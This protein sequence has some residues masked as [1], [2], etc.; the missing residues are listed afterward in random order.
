MKRYAIT[1]LGECLIDFN[2]TNQESGHLLLEGN[3][4]GA[5]A[6]VLAAA[7]KLGAK[8]C[9]IG[10]VGQDAFGD[11]LKYSLQS[12]NIDTA[13]LVSSEIFPTT[14]AFVSVNENGDRNFSFYRKST[15]DLMLSEDEI[16]YKSISESEIFHF[17]SV[18]MTSEPSRT[19]TLSAVR[20]AK[21]SNC[22]ISYDPNLRV[23]LWDN[24]DEAKHVI[25]DAMKLADIVKVSEEEALFLT[26]KHSPAEAMRQ[27]FEENPMRLLFVTLGPRGCL[28]CTENADCYLPTFD[29]ACID[30]T[31]SGDAFF[32]SVLWWLF[33]NNGQLN[34]LTKSDLEELVRLGNAA[35]SLAATCKGA[36]PSM[37]SM[38]EI[39]LCIENIPLL[40]GDDLLQTCE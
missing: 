11:F 1:A 27:L 30:T 34:A 24:L 29:T 10:K 39:M 22:L 4:G 31:G 13:G 32:G 14:L 20:F 8:T 23:L 36:I 26:G 28:A 21:E 2:F 33:K 12:C 15:A 40:Q 37:P 9:F 18:S 17:G 19:A 35:G 3:P 38:E 16:D 7:S 6:N 5:P 25:L